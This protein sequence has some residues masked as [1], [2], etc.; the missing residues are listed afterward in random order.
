MITTDISWHSVT[1]QSE[2]R[3]GTDWDVIGVD[4]V[5]YPALSS[6]FLHCK[7]EPTVG[8]GKFGVEEGIMR[9]RFISGRETEGPSVGARVSLA[10]IRLESCGGLLLLAEFLLGSMLLIA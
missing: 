3:D 7:R 4:Q 10:V 5:N 1:A 6:C 8:G 9:D 2:R